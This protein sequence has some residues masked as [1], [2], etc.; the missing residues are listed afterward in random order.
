[1]LVIAMVCDMMPIPVF[2]LNV[3]LEA[4]KPGPLSLTL[5][6]VVR[7]SRCTSMVSSLCPSHPFSP[8]MMAFSVSIYP[9]SG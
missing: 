1:M 6:T 5:M 2:F 7:C 4:L 8:C 9:Y 3:P